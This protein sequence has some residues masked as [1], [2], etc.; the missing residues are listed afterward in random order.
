MSMSTYSP[1][2]QVWCGFAL[3]Q[4]FAGDQHLFVLLSA[5]CD[6]SQSG[7]GQTRQYHLGPDH[8]QPG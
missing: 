8:M 2:A 3:I 5:G 7:F 6:S 1:A 4:W